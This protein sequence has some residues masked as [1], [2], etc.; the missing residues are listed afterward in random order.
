MDE[1]EYT[2]ST[3]EECSTT[4]F[5]VIITNHF[6]LGNLYIRTINAQN[7]IISV[8]DISA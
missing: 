6:C 2:F 5:T 8:N 3:S 1:L 7:Y 4:F